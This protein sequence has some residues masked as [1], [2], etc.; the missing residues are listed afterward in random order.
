[1][2][3]TGGQSL[4]LRWIPGHKGNEGNEKVDDEAKEAARGISSP[5]SIRPSPTTKKILPFSK[6][7][8]LII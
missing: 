7:A 3:Q 1:M 4:T 5:T 2:R 8:T 6:V